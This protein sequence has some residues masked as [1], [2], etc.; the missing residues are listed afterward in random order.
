VET[1]TRD[2]ALREYST[3]KSILNQ[4]EDNTLQREKFDLEKKE[5]EENKTLLRTRANDIINTTTPPSLIKRIFTGAETPLPED[6]MALGRELK[7][8]GVT[9][10]DPTLISR[11]DALVSRGTK[12]VLNRREEIRN[13]PLPARPSTRKPSQTDE[14]RIAELDR[15]VKAFEIETSDPN[16]DFEPTSRDL[17]RIRE[18][19]LELEELRKKVAEKSGSKPVEPQGDSLMDELNPPK[20]NAKSS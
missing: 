10:K 4:D 1:D 8:I 15:A 11:G 17:L 6:D 5:V 3:L 13:T 7:E 20:R 9:L 14:E 19:K 12:G 16:S 18:A 2:Y